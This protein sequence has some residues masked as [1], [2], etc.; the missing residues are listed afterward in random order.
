MLIAAHS[1]IVAF[2]PFSGR[3]QIRFMSYQQ[4]RR[5]ADNTLRDDL[6]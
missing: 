6:Y 2:P 3:K 1:K 5:L 4:T